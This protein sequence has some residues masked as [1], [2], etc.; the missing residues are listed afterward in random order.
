[1]NLKLTVGIST[2]LPCVYRRSDWWHLQ[3]AMECAMLTRIRRM[4]SMSQFPPTAMHKDVDGNFKTKQFACHQTHTQTRMH[5]RRQKK[6]GEE[7]NIR[8][9]ERADFCRQ[10]FN[11]S[12]THHF[13]IIKFLIHVSSY[14]TTIN[15]LSVLKKKLDFSSSV[16]AVYDYKTR[17][18][19]V[20]FSFIQTRQLRRVIGPVHAT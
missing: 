18:I 15:R 16:N 3:R 8:E 7:R 17:D 4:L 2:A 19:C 20:Q 13:I 12:S 14:K 6:R 11:N 1:M 5:M 10:S 9:R